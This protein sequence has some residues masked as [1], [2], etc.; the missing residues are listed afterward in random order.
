MSIL[1]TL[2]SENQIKPCKSKDLK[3][4]QQALG[5]IEELCLEHEDMC[6]EDKQGGIVCRIYSVCHALNGCGN[7]KDCP[8]VKEG[9]EILKEINH[10]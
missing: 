6:D 9:I 7:N 2:N 8:V 1:D 3:K 5:L 10:G 4:L